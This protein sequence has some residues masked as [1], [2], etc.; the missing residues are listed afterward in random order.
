LEVDE[1]NIE[2]LI[3]RAEVYMLKE[4]YEDAMRDFKKAYELN[5]TD[6][7]ASEGYN[8]AQK[9]HRQAGLKNYYKVLGVDKQASKNQIKKSYR[10]L[11]KAWHPDKYS[12][13][14]PKGAAKRYNDITEAYD[15]LS[16]DELRAR[17]DNGD[18]PNSQE[19][20]NHHH[21]GFNF[22]GGG[23]QFFQQGHGGGNDFHFSW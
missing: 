8:K 20:Q 12:G 17:F 3:R 22:Q 10:N 1:E 18:D 7:R 16:N 14:D 13:D 19:Q 23:H 11:A 9:L 5:K 2:A 6:S 4:E 15:V 21:G